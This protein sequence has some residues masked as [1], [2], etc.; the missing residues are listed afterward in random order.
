MHHVF[1]PDPGAFVP[2]R[3]LP[4]ENESEEQFKARVRQ[5]NEADLVFGGGRRVCSGKFVAQVEMVKVLATLF[6][7][8]NL[9]LVDPSKEMKV[10][11]SWFVRQDGIDVRIQM[12]WK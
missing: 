1:G 5:M 11:N 2:E 6:S 3:W 10:R 9:E 12:R 8:Y 7:R 4:Y